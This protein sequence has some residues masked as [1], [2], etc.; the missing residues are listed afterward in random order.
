[1][2]RPAEARQEL[3]R[4]LTLPLVQYEHVPSILPVPSHL[5]HFSCLPS[6][7]PVP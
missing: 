7:N 5:T 1:M 4:S 3:H 6:V 2:P